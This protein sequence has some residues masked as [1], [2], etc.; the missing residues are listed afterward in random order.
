MILECSKRISNV[1]MSVSI[2]EEGRKRLV[3][4]LRIVVFQ[5]L[6]LSNML[7]MKCL[8]F[9]YVL[10]SHSLSV[11]IFCLFLLPCSPSVQHLCFD[12]LIHLT[13]YEI[14]NF[15]ESNI[16]DLVLAV[17]LVWIICTQF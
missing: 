15:C 12:F 11:L 16:L 13:S 9:K 14:A 5:L 6:K 8:S 4:V 10:L 7:R 17:V 2:E 1:H 3:T